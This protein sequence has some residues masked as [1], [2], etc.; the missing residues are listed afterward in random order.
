MKISKE[1]FIQFVHAFED[2]NQ[3]EYD[4][5]ALLQPNENQIV[6]HATYR[7]ESNYKSDVKF[8]LD[9]PSGEVN[10]EVAYGW[11]DAYEEI[12]ALY[13]QMFGRSEMKDVLTNNNEAQHVYRVLMNLGLA[14]SKAEQGRIPFSSVFYSIPIRDCLPEHTILATTWHIDDIRE[15]FPEDSSDDHLFEKLR[16]MEKAITDA[17]VAAG[18]EVIQLMSKEE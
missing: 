6:Y 16:E 18:W 7:D 17:S 2:Q 10:W 13:H 3:F 14:V 15:Y 1:Q 4:D 5:T 11:N 12:D 9:V 8:S